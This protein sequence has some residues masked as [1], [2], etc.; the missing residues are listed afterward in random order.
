MFQRVLVVCIGNICRSPVGEIIFKQHFKEHFPTHEVH[1]AG[2]SALVGNP[3]DPHSCEVSLAHGY[4]LSSHKA[5]Q[6]NQELLL[7]HDLILTMET[8]QTKHIENQYPFTRGKVHTLGKWQDKEITDPYL[9]PKEAF[10]KM[11][12]EVHACALDW[13]EQFWPAKA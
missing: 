9:K 6:L 1:S 10:E 7:S 13:L 8:H 12:K 11:F 4:D 5:Q 3:A 2:I